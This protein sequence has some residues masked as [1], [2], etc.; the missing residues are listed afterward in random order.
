MFT[1]SPLLTLAVCIC[2]RSSS[3]NSSRGAVNDHLITF[4]F[5]SSANRCFLSPFTASRGAPDSAS[6]SFLD[7]D[8]PL[9]PPPPP[10]I[11]DDAPP[12]PPAPDLSFDPAPAPARPPLPPA[13]AD[14]GGFSFNV[15]FELSSTAGAGFTT[16]VC[17]TGRFG[18]ARS[19][20]ACMSLREMGFCL[21]SAFTIASYPRCIITPSTESLAFLRTSALRSVMCV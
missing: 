20:A 7:L 10:A 13:P 21:S 18:R 16:G 17:F 14:L 15:G 2:S 3:L 6:S 11:P 4:S 12:A 1:T 8:E 5:C 9:P 19:N